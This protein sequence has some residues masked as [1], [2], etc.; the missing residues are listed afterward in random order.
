MGN[1][2][3][4]SQ[5]FRYRAQGTDGARLTGTIDAADAAAAIQRVELL[6]VRV[7]QIEPV[8]PGERGYAA[9]DGT[10]T[11]ESAVGGRPL[12]GDDFIAFNE[13][14]AHL[15]TAGLPLEAGLRL[16]ARDMRSGALAATVRLVADDLER[17][18]PLG[19]A[20][21][22]HR[23]RF[24]ALYG[25]L[26][27]A[28][29]RGGNLSSVLLNLSRHLEVVHRLRA[30]LWRTLAYP[31]MVMVAIVL[32]LLFLG[33]HVVPQFRPLFADMGMRLPLLTEILFAASEATPYVAAAL[34]ALLVGGMLLWA[35]L[36]ARGLERHAADAIGL[37]LPL[38]GRVLRL[39]LI[40]RWCDALRIGV[41]AGL[42]LPAAVELAG[43]AVRS[44]RLGRDGHVLIA[45]LEAGRTLDDADD[46]DVGPAARLSVLPATV[47]TAIALAAGHNDLSSTL[48]T[49]AEMYERQA[50]SR[51]NA[52]PAVLTP[53]MLI[54]VAVTIGLVIL[55][56]VLPLIRLIEGIGVKL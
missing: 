8:P 43:D 29:V 41:T 39:N 6:Q 26:I 51:A 38:V 18:V 46:D 48:A 16:I 32:L 31:L 20:F 34:L 37:R 53:L 9:V 45:R 21:D 25:R 7:T 36:R 52:I 55:A 30:T 27:D 5:V 2:A 19:E 11:A 40:A 12:R 15:A 44:P 3:P 14:L 22:R 42:P 33:L 54:A 17:G 49:L 50:E 56:L 23:G 24:P 13:Q 1:A 35:T 4:N 10:A 28:G 47:P